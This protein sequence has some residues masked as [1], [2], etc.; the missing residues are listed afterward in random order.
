MDTVSI[1]I[2]TYNEED[3]VEIA[4][5]SI[6]NQS[7]IGKYQ[8]LF[9]IILA[10]SKSTDRTVELATPYVD[11]VM[12]VGKG[13]L[14]ARNYA[15]RYAKGNIIVSVDA[16]CYYP[17]GWL[18]TLLEPFNYEGVI[19]TRGRTIHYDSTFAW[20]EAWTL[21][22]D[23]DMKIMRPNRMAGRNCAYYKDMFFLSGGF[24]EEIDQLDVLDMVQEEEI[25]F[26]NRLAQLG[27]LIYVKD[28]ICYHAHLDNKMICRFLT[29]LPM[30][31]GKCDDYGIGTDRF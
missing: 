31:E 9:E 11:R 21:F 23:I 1:I 15:T 4:A 25:G 3:F 20:N 7:I 18:E 19:G 22:E 10:D 8:S 13:K 5:A 17:E 30:Y 27:K 24:D 29:K 28:A 2:P 16:D 14:T 12:I 26:G 6:Y